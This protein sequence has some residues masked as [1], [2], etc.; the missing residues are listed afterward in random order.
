MKKCMVL[1]TCIMI[2]IGATAQNKQRIEPLG[3]AISCTKTTNLLF[4]YNIKSVDKG[5]RDVLVQKAR[6]VENVLQ[7]KA[8][9]ENFTE[10]N[11]SVI[12][13]DGKLYSF[14]LHYAS[15]PS[16]LNIVFEKE[17]DSKF[18]QAIFPDSSNVKELQSNSEWVKDQPRMWSRKRDHRFGMHLQLNGLYIDHNVLYYQLELRNATLINYDVDLIRFFVKDRQQSKRTASQELI[19][20]PLFVSGNVQVIE[21]NSHHI[22][23]VALPKFTISDKKELIVQVM[24]KNGG[25]HLSLKLGNKSIVKAKAI[26]VS[27]SE[28]F[29][30]IK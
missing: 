16:E 4:P 3:L 17:T 19:Q 11:L 10:T 26:P 23:V 8:G 20:E 15:E 6:G 14:I 12:T 27:K 29:N 13:A 22:I 7:L 25:R 9:K 30:C 28:I 21:G 5:I 1:V 18:N 24:E 2:F